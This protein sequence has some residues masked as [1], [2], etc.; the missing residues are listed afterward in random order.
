[1]EDYES[2]RVNFLEY[3]AKSFRLISEVVNSVI[4]EKGLK[5][6]QKQVDW[7]TRNLFSIWV[8]NDP[9]IR[10]LVDDT[11]EFDTHYNKIKLVGKYLAG[12]F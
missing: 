7:Y 8:Y 12:T 11:P 10:K 1:M 3:Q 5:V 6:S 2:H 9:L 4:K